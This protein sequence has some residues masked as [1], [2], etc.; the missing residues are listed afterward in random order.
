MGLKLTRG[1]DSR[2]FL[3]RNL[4]LDDLENTAEYA[5]WLRRVV[6]TSR[7]KLAVVNV[8]EKRAAGASE[9]VLDYDNRVLDLGGGI[10]FTLVNLRNFRQEAQDYC[11]S[12]GRGGHS[13]MRELPQAHFKIDAPRDM[14]ILRDDMARKQ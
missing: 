14:K 1:V 3:G 4:V 10:V 7:R 11:G 8:Q 13:Y 5:V 6:N 2:V 9:E 12:C